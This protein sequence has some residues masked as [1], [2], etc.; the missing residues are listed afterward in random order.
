MNTVK[1]LL[2]AGALMTCVSAC[3]RRDTTPDNDTTVQGTKKPATRNV[4]EG[5]RESPAWSTST[6]S[7][8][9]VDARDV[10]D[11][12]QAH[13]AND[14]TIAAVSNASLILTVTGDLVLQG[15]AES[16]DV[17]DEL[18]DYAEKLAGRDVEN[19]IEV[20]DH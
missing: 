8:D 10:I 11:Q 20:A 16:D 1:M 13:I 3:E 18:E 6:T 17:K 12:F 5:E 14:P 7:G 19:Q 9:A 15:T 2:A 4:G